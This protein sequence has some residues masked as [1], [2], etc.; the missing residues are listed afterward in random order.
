MFFSGATIVKAG[1][2]TLSSPSTKPGPPMAKGKVRV[3]TTNDSE[4]TQ[5]CLGVS[6][7]SGTPKWMVYKGKP[8]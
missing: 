8:Y 6:K 2:E 7:N 3:S 1:F 5:P 4:T